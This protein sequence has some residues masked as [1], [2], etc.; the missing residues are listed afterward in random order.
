MTE[1]G[2]A[3]NVTGPVEA[4]N[5]TGPEGSRGPTAAV[6]LH[7][8]VRSRLTPDGGASGTARTRRGSSRIW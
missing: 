7:A 6:P 5:V 1:S 3:T 2:E 4:T 8:A